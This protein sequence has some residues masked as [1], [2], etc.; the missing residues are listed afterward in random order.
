[1]NT[2]LCVG[3]AVWD[4][5]FYVHSLPLVP[6]KVSALQYKEAGGGPAAT[7]AVTIARL[8]GN[9]ILWSKVGDDNTGRS[10]AQELSMYGVDISEI[11]IVP[12]AKSSVAAVLVDN[13]GERGIAAYSDCNLYSSTDPLPETLPANTNMILADI[14]WPEGAHYSFT[15]AQELSIPTVLDIEKTDYP[16]LEELISL[17]TYAVFS[18]DGLKSF[19]QETDLTLALHKVACV[20]HGTVCVTVGDKGCV[21][22][23]GKI[24]RTQQSFK[25][26]PIDTTGA[27]DVFHGALALCLSCNSNFEEAARFASAAAALKCTKSGGREGIPDGKILLDFLKRN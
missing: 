18:E 26:E 27:G 19:T 7:A 3:R 23:E 17:A 11:C 13:R 22:L 15:L 1:M 14:R 25:V 12:K 5:I 2:I 21:W 10:I 6:G 16:N 24:V 8:G 20:C 9:S 4:R